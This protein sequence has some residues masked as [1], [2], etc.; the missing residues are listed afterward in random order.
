MKTW[1]K[2]LKQGLSSQLPEERIAGSDGYVE[3]SSSLKSLYPYLKRHWQKGV[4]GVLLVLFAAVC[5]FPAPL[6]TRFIVDNVILGQKMG[7]L[8]GAVVLLVC[9][10]AA[11]KLATFL[12]GI[13]QQLYAALH[14]SDP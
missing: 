7:L 9:F 4:F 2:Y 1:F 3:I 6:I 8:V 5:S 13:V 10:L 11:E 14:P 12:D